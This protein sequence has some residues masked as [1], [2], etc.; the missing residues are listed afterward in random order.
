MFKSKSFTAAFIILSIMIV[1]LLGVF[2]Y[3]VFGSGK[4][5]AAI[6]ESQSTVGSRSETYS[7]DYTITEE[8][9]PEMTT[10]TAPTTT[11]EE[12]TTTEALQEGE[13]IKDGLLRALAIEETH[14]YPVLNE[15][16]PC[17]GSL[18]I[19][20]DTGLV[21]HKKAKLDGKN[22][23]GNKIEYSGTFEINGKIYILD[24]VGM[25]YLMYQTSNGYYVSADPTLV[26]YAEDNSVIAADELRVDTFGLNESGK[27][28]LKVIQEDGNHVAFSVCIVKNGELEPVLENV[29]ASYTSS[30]VAYFDYHHTDNNLYQGT[31]AFE[32]VS[33]QT[34]TRLVDIHFDKAITLN[35]TEYE[36]IVLHN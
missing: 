31:I 35:K 36:N 28:A 23:T 34:Y 1:G 19:K 8:P 32:K 5:N 7:I 26:Q 17:S 11:V 10:T 4:N 2:L 30:G 9:T 13:G 16:I 21:F 29:I 15:V 6:K 12:T 24:S 14:E 3:L 25:A 18:T 27:V 22:A 20:S 33:D